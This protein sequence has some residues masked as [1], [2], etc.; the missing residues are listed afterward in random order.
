[1]QVGDDR[2]LDG[3][4]PASLQKP[5]RDPG[6]VTH[7]ELFIGDSKSAAS[8]SGPVLARQTVSNDAGRYLVCFPQEA[9]NG[10]GLTERGQT[11]EVRARKDG[12]LPASTSFQYGYSKWDY[13]GMSL[14]LELVRQ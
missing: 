10:S 5:L 6:A 9:L 8:G 1:M 3:G 7:V 4:T 2:D 11:F 12:Y 13:G 14:N